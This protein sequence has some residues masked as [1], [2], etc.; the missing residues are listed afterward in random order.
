MKKILSLGLAAKVIQQIRPY[1]PGTYV[2]QIFC[3]ALY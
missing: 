1:L 2:M 3:H